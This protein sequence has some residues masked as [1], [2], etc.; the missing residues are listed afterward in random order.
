MNNIIISRTMISIIMIINIFRLILPHLSISI[1]MTIR[2][3][4]A[5]FLLYTWE[6]Q[7]SGH[8]QVWLSEESKH[9][10]RGSG[11]FMGL[12]FRVYRV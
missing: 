5:S 6:A 12:K 9:P 11:G 10:A 4:F 1:S 7:G 2:N 8:W 3:I